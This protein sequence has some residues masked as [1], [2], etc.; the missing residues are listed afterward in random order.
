M[1]GPSDIKR[2]ILLDIDGAPWLVLDVQTQSPSARGAATITKVKVRNLRTG[3]V[4]TRSY[5]SGEVVE[6]ADCE[7]RAVQYLYQDGDNFCFMD[8]ETYE[9]FLLGADVLGDDA[10]YLT[11]G[12]RL[13]SLLYN[14][15]AIAVELPNTVDL[16]VVDTA[17]AIKGATAQ[18]QPKPATLSTGIQVSVPPYL[19]T[20]EIVRVD[21]RTGKFVERVRGKGV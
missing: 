14:G 18:A 15:E 21:T 11:E 2:G 1:I 19:T 16:E 8:E 3:Q 7:R 5:R 10:G 4:L 20:G 17:P 9:Q 13:R 12:L 6:T